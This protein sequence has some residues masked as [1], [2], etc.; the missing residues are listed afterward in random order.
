M[1][2]SYSVEAFLKAS[3][4]DR[5]G[6]AFASAGRDVGALDKSVNGANFT[7]GKLLAAVGITA[8]VA[9]GFSMM[10]DAVSGAVSR[11]DTL[12]NFPRV[13]EMIGFST[14]ESSGAIERLT[15]GVEGL[16]TRLD[17][18]ASTA[19]R[20][21]T[22]T[23]DLDGAVETTLALNNAFISSGSDVMDAKRGLD[24]Y[25]QMLS[26]G[27]VDLESWRTLQETMGVALNDTAKAFG[28]AGESAQ[29][30]LYEA[31]KSGDITFSEF[32]EKL[33]ELSDGTG[34]FAE[35]ARTA[36]GGIQTAWAN[37]KTAIVNGVTN[38]ITAIDGFLA[39]TQFES[40]ENIIMMAKDTFL[41][42]LNSLA[43][44][45]PVLV[46][47]IMAVKE[48]L[49]P[50]IPTIL[51]IVSTFA[52]FLTTI[53][54][55]STLWNAFL[56]LKKALTFTTTAS[57]GASI[58]AKIMGG[59][60]AK[61]NV[62]ILIISA[63]ILALGAIIWHL[64][65]TN[66]EFRE[67]VMQIW[68]SIKII[69]SEVFLALQPFFDVFIQTLMTVVQ[70]MIPIVA[71][72]INVAA[73]FFGL[74]A[75]LIQ[76]HSWIIQVVAVV[77]T[78]IVAFKAIMAVLSLLGGVMAIVNFG[79]KIL[80]GAFALLTSPLL[81]K[82]AIISAVVAGL[83]WL[84]SQFEWFTD[85]VA[86]IVDT[87][88]GLW[89][90]FLDFLGFGTEEAVDKASESISGLGEDTATTTSEMSENAQSNVSDMSTGVLDSFSVMS[91]GSTDMMGGM[92]GDVLGMFGDMNNGASMDASNM[93]AAVTGDTSAMASGVTSDIH[94]MTGMSMEDIEAMT[95]GIEGD[96]GDMSS[97]STED[98]EAMSGSI[99]GDMSAMSS[100]A[101]SEASAMDRSVSSSFD[102]MSSSMS[103]GMGNV[104]KST[105][106]EMDKVRKKVETSLKAMVSSF[107]QQMTALSA[108]SK[109][110]MNKVT[111]AITFGMMKS[112]SAIRKYLRMM[113]SAM[114][115]V[116]GQ[117]RSAGIY[118]MSGFQSGLNAR[119]SSV[120]S[121]ARR[122][123]NNVASTMRR[124]LQVRSPSRVTMAIGEFTGQG[125]QMGLQSMTRDVDRV[126]Q[127]LASAAIPN[128]DDRQ[129]KWNVA[130]ALR[131]LSTDH[132]MQ[133][134][135]DL[136]SRVSIDRQPANINIRIGGTEFRSFVSDITD[137]QQRTANRRSIG[138]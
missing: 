134:R 12:N 127:D 113:V 128:I 54:I 39:N 58:Y 120:Y 25:I 75:Q 65:Q 111:Q 28:F 61:I 5:F 108:A 106:Q 60:F 93:N 34:G 59:T 9:K 10:K 81:I 29:N 118:A 67:N 18:V 122:I 78:A 116:Q 112:L 138:R 33:I 62:P 96:I 49:D 4:A 77:L 50:W 99:T 95:S 45:I 73:S 3:G 46:E 114:R 8:A 100:S 43:E 130:S 71:T 137:A 13:M 101:S 11:Y 72:V 87:L 109:Q 53:A 31:L 84:L 132:L 97:M 27:E 19:Q 133:I 68:E 123:A 74:L 79:A 44:G 47:K 26:K 21:A 57:K 91:G 36:S 38:I 70:T 30:D 92:S 110:G 76:N 85:L 104:S 82:I 89:N 90:G 32:N 125:L 51:T 126:S 119:A 136:D 94:N 6:K 135:S 35:R 86:P 121:T 17:D 20:I 24:Q 131:G 37:M 42:F 40:I 102:S 55:I 64:W 66:A 48:A 63:A 103:S 88:K 41:N 22:M 98:I 7:I 16:P 52:A 107:K 129:L 14:E 1:A 117:M 56:K 105:G 83:L 23:G 80:A 2:E 15:K 69:I 124:A 115:S